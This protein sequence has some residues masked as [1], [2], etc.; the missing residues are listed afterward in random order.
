MDTSDGVFAA[1]DQ[2][3]RLNNVGFGINVALENLIHADALSL[4]KSAGLPLW[5]MLAGHHG[6]FE[7][8]FTVES[9]KVDNFMKSAQQIRWDPILMG[10]VMEDTSVR[11]KYNDEM[12]SINTGQIRNLFFEHQGDVQEYINQLLDLDLSLNGGSNEST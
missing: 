12:I 9:N 10:E 6:E 8:V 7:L 2:L 1:L 4:C 3:M 5:L 11:F